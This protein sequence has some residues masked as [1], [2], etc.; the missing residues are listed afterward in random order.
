MSGVLLAF[1]LLP[2]L[3][4]FFSLGSESTLPACCR[5][6]GKHQC[7]MAS[8]FRQSVLSASSE[9]I[10]RALTPACSYRARLLMPFVSRVFFVPSAQAFSVPAISY[11]ELSLETVLLARHSEFRSHRKRGPPSLPA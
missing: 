8:L 6:D 3:M 2:L 1:F 9:P 4:P 7:A 10:V 11:P 5:R